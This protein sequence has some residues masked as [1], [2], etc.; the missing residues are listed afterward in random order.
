LCTCGVCGGTEYAAHKWPRAAVTRSHLINPRRLD[1]SV[2]Q[3][4]KPAP[5]LSLDGTS[6]LVPFP[7]PIYEMA[8]R[9]F[10]VN[11]PARPPSR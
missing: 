1:A 9:K 8:S 3:G 5:L 10:S 4:L 2:P 11:A 7:K 6:E